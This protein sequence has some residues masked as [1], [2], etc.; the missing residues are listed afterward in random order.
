MKNYH[1][2]VTRWRASS[3]VSSIMDIEGNESPD[4]EE[5]GLDHSVPSVVVI[6]HPASSSST[7]LCTPKS[8]RCSAQ[9]SGIAAVASPQGNDVRYRFV[10][11]M[12][13]SS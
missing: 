10:L 1:Q 6:S 4:G 11:N 2:K 9:N 3:R 7:C 13:D 8:R 12:S 5:P